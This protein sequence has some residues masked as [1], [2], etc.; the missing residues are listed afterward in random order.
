MRTGT[1]LPDLNKW[2]I[3]LI[4]IV[5]LIITT[6][7]FSSILDS[8]NNPN[9][10]LSVSLNATGQRQIVLQRNKYGHY[11]ATGTINGHPVEF[12]LDT[13]ATLVAV[14][15]HIALQIGLKKGPAF[16]SQTANGISL[17]YATTIDE[18]SLGG[19]TMRHVPA[20]ISSGMDFDQVLLGMSFLK[21]L[22]LSQ[23]G[24]TLTLTLPP[25]LTGNDTNPV[26]H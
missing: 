6:L 22:Q 4:W 5:L 17:S 11:V 12:L 23:Q 10:Q 25:E 1:R 19:L 26:T 3:A 8:I 18:L 20:S 9:Q 13:G 2:T 24:Q 7:L 16:Q 14:P 21:H 15:E